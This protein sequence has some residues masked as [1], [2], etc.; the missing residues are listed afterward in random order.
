MEVD[1][2]SIMVGMP[3]SSAP[4]DFPGYNDPPM[5]PDNMQRE[6]KEQSE[7]SYQDTKDTTNDKDQHELATQIRQCF[8]EFPK[9]L[10]AIKN[11]KLEGKSI[12]E[13]QKIWSEIE[14]I[15]GAKQ[16]LKMAV[17][18]A[19]MGVKA[20][21]D[22]VVQFTPLKIQGLH[23]V[24]NDPDVLDDIKFVCIKST[25]KMSTTPEQ[26]LGMRFL[27]TAFALH[28]M[29]SSLVTSSKLTPPAP[30][31]DAQPEIVDTDPKYANL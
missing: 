5:I 22:L 17:G 29:N 27:I 24:C 7:N 8:E 11:T 18:G 31:A 26:R 15:M 1:L 10:S 19:I 20:V 12:E 9:K 2:S 6:F 16:N 14:Y 23:Q 28:N 25:S 21:E 30:S 3:E 13:L 4:A